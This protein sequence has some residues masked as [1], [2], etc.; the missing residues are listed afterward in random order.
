MSSSPLPDSA[1]GS[2]VL[3]VSQLARQARILI[4]QHLGAV[5]V[6]GELSNFRRP[7]SGHWYF[8]LKDQGAQIRC[9][10]FAGANRR[11]RL[12]VADGL[13]VRVSGRVSLYE[14]RGDFQ[15][16]VER[17]EAAGEGALRAAFDALKEKLAAEG[18]FD[19]SRKRPLPI[20][21]RHLTIISSPS[22]AA[23]RDVLHVIERRFPGL[24][25]TLI[26]SAVQGDGAADQLVRALT[27]ASALH[28]DAVLLTRGG[29]SLEDLWAFN[30]ESVARAV[31]ACAHPVISAIGHQT[32]FAM[33]DFVADLRAPTPSAA[34]ELITPTMQELAGVVHGHFARLDR[35]IRHEFRFQQQALTALDR[36]LLDP[37]TQIAQRMVT[38]D[39]L[40]GRLR[41]AWRIADERRRN[42]IG[43]ANRTLTLLA[44]AR[45]IVEQMRLVGTLRNRLT[46]RLARSL[47]EHRL[48]LAGGA[49]ALSAV[50]PL[51]TL[52]R[53]YAVLTRAD[54]ADTTVRT[55]TSIAET[56]R[57]ETLRALLADGSLTL[58]VTDIDP[59][60]PLAAPDVD[61]GPS[62]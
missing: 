10:M 25:I 15:L 50:S 58:T 40:E 55:I 37:A 19:E 59:Q 53:G 48:A 16:I 47:N 49:R 9:A 12:A 44:P 51:N 23:L 4:E 2:S 35:A 33:T 14:P 8:T 31:A 52:S 60:P 43:T 24:Q 5:S 36:R 1:A 42:R 17:M 30:L 21:P 20:H 27:A 29:G 28:T 62:E 3:S 41:R 39:E 6:E 57:N 34:A 46:G 13:Q 22:G 26:P 54:T 32:D 7:G 61:E 45:Q 11:V 18:L 38:V 56:R